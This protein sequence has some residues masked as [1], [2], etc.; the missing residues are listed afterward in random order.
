MKPRKIKLLFL[1]NHLITMLY[2]ANITGPGRLSESTSLV[3]YLISTLI[4]LDISYIVTCNLKNNKML[5]LF[6]G[7]LALNCW[8]I[9]FTLD[10]SRAG[11]VALTALGPVILCASARFTLVFFFQDTG[12]QYKRFTGILMFLPVLDPLSGFLSLPGYLHLCSEFNFSSLFFV[13]S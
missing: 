2:I 3:P 10:P 9:V 8:Y 11:A 12:Y 4:L 6:C 13:F 7:L 1:A 5:N